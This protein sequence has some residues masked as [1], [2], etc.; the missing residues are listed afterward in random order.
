MEIKKVGVL[1]CGLM[2]SG[3]AQTA[4]SA[5]FETTVREV[6]EELI[7]K[8]FA[9]IEKSLERFAAKG[10]ITAEQQK[11]TRDRLFEGDDSLPLL[12][13]DSNPVRKQHDAFDRLRSGRAERDTHLVGRSEQSRGV[14]GP[15]P[16]DDVVAV[17]GRPNVEGRRIR[18]PDVGAVL[19][20][21]ELCRT[22]RHREAELAGNGV[23]DT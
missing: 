16:C 19:S 7:Q 10:T 12:S 5:G 1:G 23:V 2:G 6:S 15:G 18:R 4:A 22:G 3:I 8:G 20:D 13:S 17:E 11:Q 14:I 9:A 21:A